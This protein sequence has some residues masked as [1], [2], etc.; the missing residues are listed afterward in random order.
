MLEQVHFNFRFSQVWPFFSG[1]IQ[2]VRRQLALL[3]IFWCLET[4]LDDHDGLETISAQHLREVTL[5]AY[6]ILCVC[7]VLLVCGQWTCSSLVLF[8]MKSDTE[9]L[10][11][12]L[13]AFGGRGSTCAVWFRQAGIF[14][15]T[16]YKGALC[17]EPA[18]QGRVKWVV[19]AF[20]RGSA[21]S[22]HR[23]GWALN[24]LLQLWDLLKISSCFF[25][26]AVLDTRYFW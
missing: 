15:Y 2:C 21:Q 9:W 18:S 24:L 13:K 14:K 23:P 26:G 3:G 16:K 11:K 1:F 5:D 19:W 25:F 4:S 17:V 20:P 10:N 6:S 8:E 12:W 7:C 22:G